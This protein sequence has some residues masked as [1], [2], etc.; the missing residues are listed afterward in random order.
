MIKRGLLHIVWLLCALPGYAQSLTG[1]VV[2][3]EEGNPVPFAVVFLKET[4]QAVQTDA[5][6]RYVLNNLEAGPCEVGVKYLGYEP[7]FKSIT[8]EEGEK[9]VLNFKIRVQ[10]RELHEIEAKAAG[11]RTNGLSH[12]NEVEGT[13]IYAAKKNEVIEMKDI[14]A[15]TASNNARQVFS[16]VAG[17]NIWE[18]DGAGLQ[19]GVAARG[20]NPSRTSGFNTRLNGYDMSADA[21]GYPESYYTPPAEA[22]E[23][24]EVVRGAASLQYGT[25][26]GGMLNFV[27]KKGSDSSAAEVL[28]RQTVGTY[29]F[30]NSFNSVGGT[31]GKFNYYTYAQHK[32]GNGWRAYSDF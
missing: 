22:L 17:L 27:K 30:F 7:V 11:S 3:K 9:N 26:F 12:L 1:K 29:G 21:I 8:V 16:K 5:D 18:S 2:S 31:V 13:A 28:S 20:L 4:R 19:L 24:I 23:R 14:T 25:Q 10:A 32:Q 15:N 6:G